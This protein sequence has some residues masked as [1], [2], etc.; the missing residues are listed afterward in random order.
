M[1]IVTRRVKS[2]LKKVEDPNAEKFD[3]F[4]HQVL[5]AFLTSNLSTDQTKIVVALLQK[6]G[7]IA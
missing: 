5:T 6:E 3:I 1:E 4:M 7:Y 2:L